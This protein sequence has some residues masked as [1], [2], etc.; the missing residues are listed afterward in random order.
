MSSTISAKAPISRISPELRQRLEQV[1]LISFDVG[2]VIRDSKAV[3]YRC[4]KA[5][6]DAA[7][8]AVEFDESDVRKLVA[9]RRY[10]DDR[11]FSA[12]LAMQ[13]AGTKVKELMAKPNP[14][15]ELDALVDLHV[16]KPDEALLSKMSGVYWALY[17]SDSRWQFVRAIR[18]AAEGISEIKKLGYRLAAFS[19]APGVTRDQ[20]AF[21]RIPMDIFEVNLNRE[22]AREKPDPDG[23]LKISE[24]CGVPTAQMAHVGDTKGE[25]ATAKAANIISIGVLTGDGSSEQLRDAGAD[26]ICT[27]IPGLA[28]I[29]RNVRYLRIERLDS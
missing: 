1:T 14:F 15:D 11:A 23:L 25:V 24:R 21:P 6:A 20:R 27:D 18:G 13:R 17:N 3:V 2:G 26:L 12:L 5:G 19:G 9:S 28:G 16:A 4:L 22:D 10:I 7:G 29:L 8:L